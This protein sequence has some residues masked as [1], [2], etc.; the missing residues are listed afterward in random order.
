MNLSLLKYIQSF[1]LPIFDQ[2]FNFIS[3]L[4]EDMIYI[5]ITAIIYWTINKD[6]GRRLSIITLVSILSNFF[7]KMLMKVPR[8]IGIEGIRSQRVHTADGYAF[9][10]GHTQT[11]T[12]YWSTFL[13]KLSK[14]KVHIAFKI[15]IVAY[16]FLIGYSRLY[17][18]VHWPTDVFGGYLLGVA[19]CIIGS[20]IYDAIKEVFENN[21][22]S[23]ANII[24][25][26]MLPLLT[27]LA[28]IFND[29]NSMIKLASL[30]SGLFIGMVLEMKTLKY[31]IVHHKDKMTNIFKKTL[32][33]LVGI[34]MIV[35]IALPLKFIF[36][37]SII[38]RYFVIGFS[39][40]YLIPLLLKGLFKGDF[41]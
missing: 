23:I 14:V 30:S 4:G 10:S 6:L 29:T 36:G 32:V 34:I 28:L 20:F 11:A 25:M 9:P 16:L 13:L 15:L 27:I 21:N 7:I 18:G 39:I 3:F 31:Q 12:S 33:N 38:L 17:L 41:E 26:L 19:F 1:Y 35:L 5:L 24:T 2:I 22:K 8:P 37:E 40:I